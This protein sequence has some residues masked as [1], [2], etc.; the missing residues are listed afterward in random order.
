MGIG[1]YMKAL[2]GLTNENVLARLNGKL[3]L[4]V[5]YFTENTFIKHSNFALN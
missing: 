1:Y 3:A 2:A 4:I 5:R